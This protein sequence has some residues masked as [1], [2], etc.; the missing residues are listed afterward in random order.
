MSVE[1]SS[2]GPDDLLAAAGA[3]SP[4]A[5]P[6][7]LEELRRILLGEEQGRLAELGLTVADLQQLLADK[8][9]LAAIIAPSLE[10]A[11]RDEIQQRREEMIEVLYPIIGQTV[12]R[13]VREAIQELA[14]AVDARIRT[15]VA[16]RSIARRIRARVTGVSDAELALRDALPFQVVEVFAIHRASGLLLRHVTLTGPAAEPEFA[17]PHL[18]IGEGER[19]VG[20]VHIGQRGPTPPERPRPDVAAKTTFL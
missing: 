2:L 9:A 10:A 19:I 17:R 18:G 1:H 20:L 12:V 15:S 16:P 6:Q 8:E 11:L 3:P 4:A 13:A 7:D 14:V 5:Q